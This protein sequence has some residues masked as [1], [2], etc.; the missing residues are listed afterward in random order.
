[1][2][3]WAPTGGHGRARLLAPESVP[4]SGVRLRLQRLGVPE[5]LRSVFA[6]AALAG[7][8][9]FAVSGVF[10]SGGARVSQLRAG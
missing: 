4:R 8:A 3:S 5:R 2:Y 10:S 7:V 6:R 1:M 9:A